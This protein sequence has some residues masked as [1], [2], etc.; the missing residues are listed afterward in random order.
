M[1][2]LATTI[3]IAAYHTHGTF[4]GSATL[5][6]QDRF[7]FTIALGAIWLTVLAGIV[8]LTARSWRE[9]ANPGLVSLITGSLLLLYSVFG[10]FFGVLGIGLVGVFVMLSARPLR[11]PRESQWNKASLGDAV[12]QGY[13]PPAP[14]S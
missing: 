1:W 3:V 11:A 7:L 8:D 4:G 6:Q 2:A 10:L 12:S 14:G 5:L 13:P 9:S